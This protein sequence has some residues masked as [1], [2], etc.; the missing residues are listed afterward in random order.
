MRTTT[1]TLGLARRRIGVNQPAPKTLDNGVEILQRRTTPLGTARSR[2]TRSPVSLLRKPTTRKVVVGEE[3]FIKIHGCAGAQLKPIP[4]VAYD[5]GLRRAEVLELRWSQLD[6]ESGAIR[7]ADNETKTDAARAVFLT[8][9]AL[10]ALQAQPRHKGS[11]FVFVN[12]VERRE[13]DVSPG[14]QGAGRT[15]GHMVSRPAAQRDQRMLVGWASRSPS[16]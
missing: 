5:L 15:S 1:A 9:R 14:V 7:L 16:S 4:V 13:E 2:R 11:D 6:L 3:M 8:R 12:P 10:D